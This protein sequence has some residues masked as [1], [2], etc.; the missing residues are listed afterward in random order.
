[1]IV[2]YNPFG[3][4][5]FSPSSFSR[6]SIYISGRFSSMGKRRSTWIGEEAEYLAGP[7]KSV[8]RM[9]A[10]PKVRRSLSSNI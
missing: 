4:I 7:S 2:S 10:D 6:Y 3:V 8:H 5:D 1:M 9:R